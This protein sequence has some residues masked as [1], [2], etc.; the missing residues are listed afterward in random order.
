MIKI[1]CYEYTVTICQLTEE[2]NESYPCGRPA[3][4]FLGH[5]LNIYIKINKSLLDLSRPAVQWAEGYHSHYS[6]TLL[7]LFIRIKII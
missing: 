1:H 5:T 2:G 4:H 6:Y 3:E 7:R